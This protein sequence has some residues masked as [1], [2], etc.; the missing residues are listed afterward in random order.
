MHRGGTDVLRL[1]KKDNKNIHKR[2]HAKKE[3]NKKNKKKEKRCPQKCILIDIVAVGVSNG[4]LLDVSHCGIVI[5][6]PGLL[7]RV[8][9]RC[10]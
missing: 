4:R 7:G 2:T 9:I 5:W 6:G 1:R 8:A 10:A 3:R